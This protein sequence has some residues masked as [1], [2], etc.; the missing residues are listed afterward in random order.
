LVQGDVSV[1]LK[2][3]KG[4]LAGM[5]WCEGRVLVAGNQNSVRIGVRGILGLNFRDMVVVMGYFW[6]LKRAARVWESFAESSPRS[7]LIVL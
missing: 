5:D 3:G 6:G 2:H 7:T 1:L 4:G